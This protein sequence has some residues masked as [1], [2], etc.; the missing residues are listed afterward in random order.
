MSVAHSVIADPYI[1][2]PKGVAAA[3]ANKVYVSN[4]LGSGTWQKLASGQI[5]TASVFNANKLIF[6]FRFTDLSTASSQYVVIPVAGT[7]T[8]IY[9]I[10][11]G[12]ITVADTIFTFKNAS[13][14]SMGTMTVTQS[15]SAAADIDSLTP[16]ANN[17]FAAGAKL[18]IVSD[19]GSAGTFDEVF[20][21]ML[22][23][24]A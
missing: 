13:G 3:L 17:T 19:G 9:G 4:G 24:T 20:T 8:Q 12:A 15:G 1:H 2:E 22:T 21:F 7:V 23:Q 6:T 16:G 11:Q 5:D 10:L 14:G 18:E